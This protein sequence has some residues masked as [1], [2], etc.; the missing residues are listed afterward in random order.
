MSN[1]PLTKWRVTVD[2]DCPA[3]GSSVNLLSQPESTDWYG[4]I[5]SHHFGE[6]N[7]VM[8]TCE[9]CGKSFKAKMDF[10]A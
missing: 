2:A 1:K 7:A 9:K 4:L 5:I 8:A 3:C 6:C 10:D